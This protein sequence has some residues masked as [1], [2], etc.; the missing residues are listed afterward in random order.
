MIPHIWRAVYLLERNSL[1][2]DPNFNETRTYGV[3]SINHD[4]T[5]IKVIVLGRA[6]DKSLSKPIMTPFMAAYMRHQAS[7]SQTL[8]FSI[9]DFETILRVHSSVI[10]KNIS[11]IIYPQ[12]LVLKIPRIKENCYCSSKQHTNCIQH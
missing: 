8:T 11:N 10:T 7:T 3:C 12:G 6:G 1:Y 4:S 2:F 5:L 9:I